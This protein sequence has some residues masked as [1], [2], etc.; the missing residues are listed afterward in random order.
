MA[1][2]FTAGFDSECEHC[3]QTLEEGDQARFD[4]DY[5]FAVHVSCAREARAKRLENVCKNC[6]LIHAG[7]CE[8]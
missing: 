8:W 1:D 6:Y 7:G 3:G 4:D 2:V 5:Q